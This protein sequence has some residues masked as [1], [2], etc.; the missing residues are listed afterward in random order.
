MDVNFKIKIILY[1][2]LTTVK[3]FVKCLLAQCSVTEWYHLADIFIL[4]KTVIVLQNE[5]VARYIVRSLD[6]KA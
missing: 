4:P 2:R 1:N 6:F 3:Q 5:L